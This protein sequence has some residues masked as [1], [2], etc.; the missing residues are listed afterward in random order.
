MRPVLPLPVGI[1]MFLLKTVLSG[2]AVR[3]N[4]RIQMIT[5]RT[6]D[7]ILGQ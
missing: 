7:E 1:L 2:V 3:A 6:R 4:G 5:V